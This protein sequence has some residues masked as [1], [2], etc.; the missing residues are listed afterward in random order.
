MTPNSSV[1]P[2]F[3]SFYCQGFLANKISNVTISCSKSKP[4][5]YL[6]ISPG[7]GQHTYNAF[8]RHGCENESIIKHPDQRW[9]RNVVLHPNRAVGR[10]SGIDAW[11]Y[12]G[13]GVVAE[14]WCDTAGEGVGGRSVVQNKILPSSPGGHFFLIPVLCQSLWVTKRGTAVLK[15]TCLQGLE[16]KMDSSK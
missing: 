14:V 6:F 1:S 13:P 7:E 4:L 5:A 12:W 15:E 9:Q 11:R 8:L 10:E 3:A 2:L 16:M